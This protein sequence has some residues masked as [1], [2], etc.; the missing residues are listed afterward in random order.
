MN[1][2]VYHHGKFPPTGIDWERLVPLIGPATLALGDFRGLLDAVPDAWV[3]LSPLTTQEA[4]L[5]SRIEGTQATLGEVLEFEAGGKPPQQ[6]PEKINDIEEVINYRVAIHEAARRL[7]ELPL[8]GR[9]LKETHAI[10]MR[11]VRGRD[12]AAGQFKTT[13]NAIGAPGCTAETAKFLPIEP[14]YLDDGISLWENYLHSDQPDLLIQLAVV[15]AEFEALHPFL[16]GN[17]RLGR[18]LVPLFLYER[19]VLSHPA[20]YI[21]EYLER[22]RE[23]YYERLLAVSRDN[24]WTGWIAFFLRAMAEQARVNTKRA[25]AILQLYEDRKRWI[26][27]RTHSQYAVAALDFMFRQPIF[28]GSDFSKAQGIPKPTAR[29]ILATIREALLRELRPAAGQRPAIYAYRELLNAAE[30]KEAF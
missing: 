24:D 21:S 9:L 14:A 11:G 7:A 26:V 3:L 16:D 17:G 20:F 6:T 29:R 30:G 15:H 28:S 4:V 19:K 18:M 1:A 27:E 5:S 13:P 23:E 25:R 8:C 10:L 22:H 2:V 12:K